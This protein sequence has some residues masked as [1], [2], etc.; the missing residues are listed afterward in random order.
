MLMKLDRLQ[1]KYFEGNTTPKEEQILKKAGSED[2]DLYFSI[3]QNSEHFTRR[4]KNLENNISTYINKHKKVQHLPRYS[5]VAAASLTILLVSSLLINNILE[6]R[7]AK[8]QVEAIF[9]SPEKMQ[10]LKT[11]FEKLNKSLQISMNSIS[12]DKLDK[13]IN[14]VTAK[15]PAT[16][17]KQAIIDFKEFKNKKTL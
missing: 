13:N 1:Q 17:K 12:V 4:N 2:N 9:S 14:S 10:T 15:L 3:L 6:T 5:I 16:V 7:R 8:L 11:G